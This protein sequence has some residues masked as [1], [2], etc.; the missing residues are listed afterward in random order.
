M[1]VLIVAM[2][3]LGCAESSAQLEDQA[4]AHARQATALA[5]AQQYQHASEEQARASELHKEAVKRAVK[6]GR[7]GDLAFVRP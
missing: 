5:Q 1:R 4:N 6:E 2:A 3:M 7:A